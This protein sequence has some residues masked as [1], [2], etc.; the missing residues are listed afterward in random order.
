MEEI[1]YL[2]VAFGQVLRKNREQSKL[3]QGVLAAKIGSVTSYIRF[4]E[5]GQ[6]M[7]T[8]NTFHLICTALDVDPHEFISEYLQ[9]MNRMKSQDEEHLQNQSFM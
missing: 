4:L 2:A 1:S 9:V 7:P 5:Y 8:I 3:T 6:N